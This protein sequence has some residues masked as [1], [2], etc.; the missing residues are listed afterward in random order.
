[1]NIK[2][3]VY[4]LEMLVGRDGVTLDTEVVFDE[5]HGI[6]FGHRIENAEV[7]T[8]GDQV[9]KLIVLSPI[10]PQLT[11]AKIQEVFKKCSEYDT[12]LKPE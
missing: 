7:D 8:A 4:R 6:R 12:E 1:M 10:K 3:L 5:K 11:H 9:S 2:E